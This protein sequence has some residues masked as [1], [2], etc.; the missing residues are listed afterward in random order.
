MTGTH[1][2][3]FDD[4]VQQ[5][6][7]SDLPFVLEDGEFCTLYHDVGDESTD[8]CEYDHII[9]VQGKVSGYHLMASEQQREMDALTERAAHRDTMRFTP[10]DAAT[11]AE[12]EALCDRLEREYRKEVSHG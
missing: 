10:L 1:A 5:T 9:R 6:G 7:Q 11:L 4:F 12:Y 3:T 8:L 2:M